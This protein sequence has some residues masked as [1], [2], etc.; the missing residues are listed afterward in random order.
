MSCPF[1]WE[2]TG[3][4]PS[5]WPNGFLFKVSSDILIANRGQ[6][7]L[8]GPQ[9]LRGLSWGCH[10]CGGDGQG[11][12]GSWT[13]P[14]ESSR[15]GREPR[16]CPS[17]RA[18]RPAL[19]LHRELG[20][21]VGTEGDPCPDAPPVRS[22]GCW[23]SHPRSLIPGDTLPLATSSRLLQSVRRPGAVGPARPSESWQ[24]PGKEAFLPPGGAVAEAA[25][26]PVPGRAALHCR[27]P[28]RL[29]GACAAAPRSRD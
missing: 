24:G 4:L 16:P 7:S 20:R 12:A 27:L 1:A 10:R 6:P 9:A 17:A 8:S 3:G 5:P 22:P 23:R 15:G 18:Q 26:F 21:C 2:S 29:L 19:L 28:R 11:Q 25:G 14:K 13:L